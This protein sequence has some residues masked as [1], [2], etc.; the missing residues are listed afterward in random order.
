MVMVK[1]IE[2]ILLSYHEQDA[3]LEKKS[4]FKNLWSHSQRLVSMKMKPNRKENHDF[5]VL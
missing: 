4:N 1:I 3:I 5:C 2:A